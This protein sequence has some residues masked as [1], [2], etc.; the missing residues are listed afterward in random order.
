LVEI[1]SRVVGYQTLFWWHHSN[2]T[3]YMHRLFLMPNWRNK[4]IEAAM[5][6][7]AEGSIKPLAQLHPA[8]NLAR[9]FLSKT[10][11]EF[12]RLFLRHGYIA[13]GG[14]VSLSLDKISDFQTPLPNG[15][16][17]RA[18]RPE[19]YRQIWNTNELVFKNEPFRSPATEENYQA[20]LNSPDFNP[21]LW[22]AIWA[23]DEV[24]GVVI[25]DI[26]PEN[27]GVISQL[28]VAQRWRR[29]SLGRILVE[30]ALS[31]LK[32]HHIQKVYVATD[33]DN[34]GAIK[35]YTSM[36]FI[37]QREFVYYQKAID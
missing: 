17:Q 11:K 6:L 15:F 9:T 28:S 20:F 24:A 22:S 2:G 29:R 33:T 34:I 32:K 19:L 26:T 12:T 35:L 3:A 18:I 36:N 37:P 30:K 27:I 21:T 23:G 25:C 7:W 31:L 1:D 16:C 13:N 5:L 4:G 14:L 10:E 8:P